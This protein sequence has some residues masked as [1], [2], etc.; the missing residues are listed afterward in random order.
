MYHF[1]VSDKNNV[2]RREHI[3]NEFQKIGVEPNFFDAII[4][5]SLAKEE[6]KAVRNDMNY[7][8]AGEIGCVLSHKKILE[9]FLES[10]HKS[11]IIFEDDILF[12]DDLTYEILEDLECLVGDMEGPSVLSLYTTEIIYEEVSK[13][14]NIG[15]NST[16]RFMRSHGYI[17]NRNGAELILELQTP[18]KFEYDQFK[19][20]HYLKGCELYSLDI[21]YVFVKESVFESSIDCRTD[22][23]IDDTRERSR[24]NNIKN[25]VSQLRLYEKWLYYKRK[26]KKHLKGKVFQKYED[27]VK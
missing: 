11:V 16:P 14:H 12:S 2:K 24:K 5:R 21:N 19:F 22:Q 1:V 26:I 6:L 20:Y 4:G 27:C 7:L 25:L 13:L 10:K 17:I 15:I 9:K 18:I 8:T 23:D 3:I